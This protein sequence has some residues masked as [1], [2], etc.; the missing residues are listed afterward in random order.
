LKTRSD[1]TIL[2]GHHRIAILPERGEDI[3][4]LPREK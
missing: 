2:D 4:Q 3:H 1:G